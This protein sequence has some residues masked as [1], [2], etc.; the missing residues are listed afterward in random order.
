MRHSRTRPALIFAALLATLPT[1]AQAD[2]W[3]EEWVTGLSAPLYVTAPPG[4]PDRLF[5]VEQGGRIRIFEDGALKPLPFLD[6]SS[7]T[8]TG[9]ERGLLGLAFHPDYAS[10]GRFYI[11]HTGASS[12]MPL[13]ERV[14]TFWT[15]QL[16]AQARHRKMRKIISQSQDIEEGTR[17]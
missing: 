2:Y 9:G 1:L 11:N 3:L 6:L 10:N 5:I 17:S 14:G 8:S 13:L 12:E 4:D 16:T 7:I 15:L